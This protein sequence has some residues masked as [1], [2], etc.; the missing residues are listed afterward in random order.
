VNL[1]EKQ[2]LCR[3]IIFHMLGLEDESLASVLSQRYIHK[4]F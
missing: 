2:L 4:V 3:G 1:N